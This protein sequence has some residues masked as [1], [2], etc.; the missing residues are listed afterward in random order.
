MDPSSHGL[1]RI[2]LEINLQVFKCH[3]LSIQP[4]QEYPGGS[5]ENLMFSL[6]KTKIFNVGK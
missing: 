3:R 5:S 2:E 6:I 4:K 1:Y